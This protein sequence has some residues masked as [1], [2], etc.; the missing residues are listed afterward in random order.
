MTSVLTKPCGGMEFK[1]GN[2]RST[3]TQYI[4]VEK[5]FPCKYLFFVNR[6]LSEDE[7]NNKLHSDKIIKYKLDPNIDVNEDITRSPPTV[8]VYVNE[9]DYPIF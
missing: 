4:T 1:L 7:A 9:L 8:T 3:K 6:F 2:Q 5:I